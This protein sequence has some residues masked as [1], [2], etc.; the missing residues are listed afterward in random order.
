MSIH[1]KLLEIIRFALLPLEKINQ[2]DIE[3]VA[4]FF[5]LSLLQLFFITMPT[6]RQHENG[7]NK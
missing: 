7:E 2:S 4:N 6:H 1:K 5:F 3:L